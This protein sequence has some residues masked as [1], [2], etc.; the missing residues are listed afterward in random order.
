MIPKQ[1]NLM[2]KT[3]QRPV[4]LRVY[5]TILGTKLSVKSH[6]RRDRTTVGLRYWTATSYKFQE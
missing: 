3:S 4:I 5:P 1:L 6:F 2:N